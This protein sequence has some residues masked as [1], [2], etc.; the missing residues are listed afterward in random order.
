MIFTAE[1]I[2]SRL[3][4]RPFVPARFVTTAGQTYDIYHPDLV[5]VGYSFLI[6]GTPAPDHPALADAVTRIPLAHVT[7]IR[8]LPAAVAPPTQKS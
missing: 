6:I 1:N 7:E 3:R 2:Q 8:D 5:F 4:D